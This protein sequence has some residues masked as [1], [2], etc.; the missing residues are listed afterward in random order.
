MI[1]PALRRPIAVC[2]LILLAASLTWGAAVHLRRERQTNLTKTRAARQQIDARMETARAQAAKR[3][4]IEQ[5]LRD[6]IEAHA[7]E[8]EQIIRALADDHRLQNPIVHIQP[9]ADLPALAPA[10]SVTTPITTSVTTPIAVP[11]A[12]FQRLRV[13]AGLLHEE[14]L[15]ELTDTFAQARFR[16]LGCTLR[17]QGNDA[18]MPL[19]VSCEF[20]WLTLHIP[21]STPP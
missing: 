15:L 10:A 16:P 12:N 4:L 6:I 17:R 2:A 20:E 5:K 13:D 18:P 3:E 19:V 21:D 14:A 11:I 9:T 7:D 1:A 8:P